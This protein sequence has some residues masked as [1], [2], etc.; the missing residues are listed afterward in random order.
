M[1]GLKVRYFILEPAG[2]KPHAEACRS[3]IFA[4][5]SRMAELGAEPDRVRDLRAWAQAKHEEI[6]GGM[7]PDA[8]ADADADDTVSGRRDIVEGRRTINLLAS[9]E[10]EIHMMRRLIE[11]LSARVATM[12]LFET[13]LNTQ[14]FVRQHGAAPDTDITYKLAMERKRLLSETPDPADAENP[15]VRV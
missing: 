9:A 4:Y 5:C 13:M 6:Y 12:D 8:D 14:P 2:D 7:G 3:A 11:T 10:D 1:A 15:G